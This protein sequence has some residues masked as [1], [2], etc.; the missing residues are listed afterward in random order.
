M[1][2]MRPS[3]RPNKSAR[4]QLSTS[5]F[6]ALELQNAPGRAHRPS[7]SDLVAS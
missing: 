4:V 5:S 1:E 2:L 7:F 3:G 6:H